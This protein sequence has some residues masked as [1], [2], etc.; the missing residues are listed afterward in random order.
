MLVTAGRGLNSTLQYDA[1]AH[2][3]T[4]VDGTKYLPGQPRAV[5]TQP[6]L[7]DYL[8]KALAVPG[9]DEIVKHLWWVSTR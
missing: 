8:Q 9:L 6:E 5:L 3:L 2:P 4:R 7:G 1:A